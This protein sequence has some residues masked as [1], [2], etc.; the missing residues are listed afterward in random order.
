MFRTMK[1]DADDKPTIGQ[2]ATTL[3][4]RPSEVDVD[5]QGNVIPNSKGMSVAPAW[6]VISIFM[7]PRRLG[8]GGRGSNNLHCFR[9][10][11]ALFQQCPCG[12]G[13]ELLPDS[14]THGVVRPAQLAPL[15]QFLAD[16]AATRD[17][18]QIDEA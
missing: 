10:G 17:E 1:K 16:L 2:T 18:W 4:V 8:T 6:R 13:L 15:A 3:G 14:P 9:R 5:A 11:Q 12:A 7:I